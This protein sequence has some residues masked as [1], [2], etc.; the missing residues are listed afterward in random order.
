[1]VWPVL[2]DE[3]GE[4]AHFYAMRTAMILARF[5]LLLVSMV[6]TVGL[7]V[8]GVYTLWTL[9]PWFGLS[10]LLVGPTAVG[11]GW[12]MDNLTDQPLPLFRVRK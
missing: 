3:S 1:V 9:N 8:V 11:I 7:I 12:L 4:R 2:L 6:A 10:G 5:G